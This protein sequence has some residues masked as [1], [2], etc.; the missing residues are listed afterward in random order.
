[1]PPKYTPTELNILLKKGTCSIYRNIC[2]Y[3]Q[4]I[5]GQLIIMHI[6]LLCKPPLII[7]KFKLPWKKNSAILNTTLKFR[8]QIYKAKFLNV[9]HVICILSSFSTHLEETIKFV[10]NGFLGMTSVAFIFRYNVLFVLEW[11][12]NKY[13][14][15]M[16][17]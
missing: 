9:K 1:M 4:K 12:I 5:H 15:S 16:I 13:S 6:A 10:S 2:T 7:V 14:C 17:W 8:K 11:L 3:R